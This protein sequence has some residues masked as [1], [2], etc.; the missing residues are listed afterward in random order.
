M[1]HAAYVI[2]DGGKTFY[3]GRAREI[4]QKCCGKEYVTEREQFERD[5]AAGAYDEPEEKTEGQEAGN[6]A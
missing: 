5:L 4:D 1:E 6:D 3:V 2:D